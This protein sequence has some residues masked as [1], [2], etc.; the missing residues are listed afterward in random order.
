MGKTDI[1][2]KLESLA[3]LDIDAFHA[4]G[5]AIE[6]ITYQSIRENFTKF[7]QDHLR[8]VEEISALIREMG[9]VPPE[10]SRDFK[11]FLLEGFTSLR[12]LS[13]TQGALAA[14]RTNEKITNSRYQ[15]ATGL[16]LPPEVHTLL[17][18]NY[19]DEQRHLAYIEDRLDFLVRE[20]DTPGRSQRY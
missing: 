10:F 8:H 18:K 7:Q 14:M 20:G 16:D 2:K 15:D 4:Y 6:K 9:Q 5:Q 17:E 13:G 3:Q 12:S 1:I 11:G 19:S